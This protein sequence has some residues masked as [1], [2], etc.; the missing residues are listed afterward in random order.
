MITY[1]HLALFVFSVLFSCPL[2]KFGIYRNSLFPNA[3]KAEEAPNQS[4]AYFS[5]QD[6]WPLYTLRHLTLIHLYL[7]KTFYLIVLIFF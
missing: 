3:V 5:P 2:T 7:M 6:F 4:I 1:T